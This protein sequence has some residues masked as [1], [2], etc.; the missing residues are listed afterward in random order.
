MHA[1]QPQLGVDAEPK[2]PAVAPAPEPARAAVAAS[3]QEVAP[4]HAEQPQLGVDAELAPPSNYTAC[5][6]APDDQDE[7]LCTCIVCMEQQVVTGMPCARAFR[8]LAVLTLPWRWQ[9][10]HVLMPCRHFSL[11]HSCVV[12]LSHC[13]LC[14]QKIEYTLRIYM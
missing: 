6:K 8:T 11:C 14:N 9:R 5:A 2:P 7:S 13:P 3:L 10:T 12:Q 1:E 4:V